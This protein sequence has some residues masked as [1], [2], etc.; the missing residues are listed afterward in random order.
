MATTIKNNAPLYKRNSWTEQQRATGIDPR[1]QD[2]EQYA[3]TEPWCASDVVACHVTV[4]PQCIPRAQY[5][6]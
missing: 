4:L 1:K 5:T 6:Q 2:Y 3:T